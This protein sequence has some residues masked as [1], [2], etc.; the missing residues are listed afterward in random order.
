MSSYDWCCRNNRIHAYANA[1]VCENITEGFEEGNVYILENFKVKDFLGDEN[2]RPVRNNKHIYFSKDTKWTREN[3]ENPLKIDKYAFDLV[4]MKDI[5]KMANDN[6][7]LVDGDDEMETPVMTVMQ[8][9]SLQLKDIEEQ[10]NCEIVVTKVVDRNKCFNIKTDCSDGSGSIEVMFSDEDVCRIIGKKVDDIYCPQA[11]AKGEQFFPDILNQL[12]RQKYVI[13]LSITKHN[14]ENSS[15]VYDAT[16]VGECIESI[17]NTTPSHQDSIME[18][19]SISKSNRIHAFVPAVAAD[20]L[21]SKFTVGTVLVIRNFTVQSYKP[22]DKFRC[23]RKEVQLI[24]SNETHIDQVEDD[25]R[26]IA[27]NAFDFVDHSELMEMTKQTTYL[28]GASYIDVVGIIKFRETISDLVN[29]LGNAQKQSK[30]T[31]TDGRSNIKVTFWDNFA[32]KFEKLFLQVV[33]EPV[34]IILGSCRVGLWNDEVDLTSVAATECFVNYNHFSVT[35]LRKM[36]EISVIATDET[37]GIQV[38]LG[39]QQ[40][41]AILQKRVADVIKEADGDERFPQDL[42]QLEKKKYTL[43]LTIKE[44]NVLNK[45]QIYWATNICNG[46]YVPDDAE[47]SIVDEGAAQ[48]MAKVV[49][50]FICLLISVSAYTTNISSNFITFDEYIK[51]SLSDAKLLYK[52]MITLTVVGAIA[53]VLSQ[54]ASSIYEATSVGFRFVG[55]YGDKVFGVAVAVGDK[56]LQL[57]DKLQLGN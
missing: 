37:G 33:E 5:A 41:R 6:H 7:F 51:L 19:M 8:I 3:S 24:F 50:T 57:G 46:F 43:K 48:T 15:T 53:F 29:R 56:T 11:E 42:K 2:Y 38:I 25:G 20:T 45:I 32:L 14:I 26:T 13:T 35:H 9:K 30:F 16:N 52:L 55:Y 31:I 17:G 23:V 27:A 1:K 54:F 10:V 49:I 21:E 36:F 44:V 40:V 39:D 4:H 22:D 28:A 34:I 12:V 18:P 47:P